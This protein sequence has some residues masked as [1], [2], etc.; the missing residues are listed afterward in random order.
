MSRATKPDGMLRRIEAKAFVKHSYAIT[1]KEK[2]IILKHW[3]TI[4]ELTSTDAMIYTQIGLKKKP[5][6][7]KIDM[8]YGDN[9][10]MN[11]ETYEPRINSDKVLMNKVYIGGICYDNPKKA[12]TD[13]SMQIITN[14]MNFSTSEKELKT[15][16]FQDMVNKSSTT[17]NI[18]FWKEDTAEFK[19]L[20][21][22]LLITPE[23]KDILKNAK[24]YSDYADE[25]LFWIIHVWEG[26]N[27]RWALGIARENYKSRFYVMNCRPDWTGYNYIDQNRVMY[28]APANYGYRREYWTAFDVAPL[29]EI[30]V[31]YKTCQNFITRMENQR[32]VI[33]DRAFTSQQMMSEANK[34][35]LLEAKNERDRKIAEMK[36]K[37]Y[38]E[39][40][41]NMDKKPLMKNNIAFSKTKMENE[42][43]IVDTKGVFSFNQYLQSKSIDELADFNT[44]YQRIMNTIAVFWVDSDPPYDKRTN[45]EPNSIIS[46]S[47]NSLYSRNQ[48]SFSVDG[49]RINLERGETFY[50]INSIRINKWEIAE[51]LN[52]ILCY[53]TLADYNKFLQSVSDCSLK[54]HKAISNNIKKQYGHYASDR[55]SVEL[56]MTRK[57][58]TNYLVLDKE[59]FKL[60]N[61]NKLID[62]APNDLEEFVLMI[63]DVADVPIKKMK[64][65][66]EEGKTR[67]ETALAKSKEL[68]DKTMK[69]LKVV[70]DTINSKSGFVI[71]GLS[72]KTYLVEDNDRL[73]VWEVQGTSMEYR[74]IVDKTKSGQV[75]KDA[76]VSRLYALSNDTLI[77]G[78]VTTLRV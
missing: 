1:D 51:C 67:Y 14:M 70:K 42:K 64:K 35:K 73:Q 48:I 78:E 47:T 8:P 20:E 19:A 4:K 26:K 58:K 44:I 63:I 13:Q 46:Q 10:R 2:T 22:K 57:G 69:N 5:A 12:S 11:F 39:A 74:C 66:V 32:V 37:K 59:Q 60:R 40:L 50:F 75:G 27:I 18:K 30:S 76:L 3:K 28:L 43:I 33:R 72:G 71:H 16:T 38:K 53:K 15:L 23:M 65:L 24:P 25:K 77:A 52:H 17:N 6:W 29:E 34:I 62:S 9:P 54:F 68:L 61:T 31:Y 7:V 21:D 49:K 45:T 36:N 56:K 41:S 55:A